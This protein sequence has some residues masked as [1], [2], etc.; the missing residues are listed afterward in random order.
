MSAVRGEHTSA[1]DGLIVL[2]YHR[3]GAARN[4]WE[5]RYA[6]GP[7][8]FEAHM[9]ALERS[10]MRAVPV[11][12]LSAWL[13]GGERPADGAFVLTF[14]DGFHDVRRNAQPVLDRM[15]WPFTMFL[16]SGLIGKD[17]VWT[18]TSNPDGVTYPLLKLDEILD[19]QRQGVTFHSHSCSHPSLIALDDDQLARELVDSRAALQR[20]LGRAVDYFAYPFGHVD[21]R[22][23]E[24]TRRAG[25]RAA[26]S[27]QPGFNRNDVDR[28]RIRRIDVYGTDTPSMLMRKV[29]LG[30]ND[31]S[32]ANVARYYIARAMARL[33]SAT[34]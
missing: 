13:D 10:G 1:P 6:I 32:A 18:R 4:A 22:V 15:H 33:P 34:R 26:F 20:M 30:T 23:V 5:S 7:E 25:Y 29:R 17:D 21:D 12:S 3:V 31:G 2:M 8:R 14:D 27:T 11:E 16:V 9:R 19:M 24:A 28:F